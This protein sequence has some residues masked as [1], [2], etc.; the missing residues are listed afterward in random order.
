MQQKKSRVSALSDTEIELSYSI[1][2]E[3]RRALS[4]HTY[5]YF[6]NS[7]RKAVVRLTYTTKDGKVHEITNTEINL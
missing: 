2:Y 1:M 6:E 3:L 5:S 4:L 7:E